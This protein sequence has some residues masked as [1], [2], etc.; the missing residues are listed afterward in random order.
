V[1]VE[2]KKDVEDAY[3]AV[4]ALRPLIEQMNRADDDEKR[5]EEMLGRF[6]TVVMRGKLRPLDQSHP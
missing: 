1:V 4:E 5:I 2:T 3:A 6:A